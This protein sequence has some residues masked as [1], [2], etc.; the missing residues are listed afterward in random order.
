M[1]ATTVSGTAIG[2]DLT[3]NISFI[4]ES[5][6]LPPIGTSN[7]SYADVW[8][9]NGYAYVGS[10]RSGRGTA[11]FSISNSGIPRYLAQY[12]GI[13]GDGSEYEDVEV[14]DGIGYFGADVSPTSSGTGVDIVDLSIPFDPI[15]L[16]RVN[17]SDCLSGSPTVCA[18][19]KVHTLSI[20]RFNPYTPSE[21]RFLYTA[22]NAT[23][24]V[25]ITDVSN[26][27]SP[28]LIASL[29]LSLSHPPAPYPQ[30]PGTVASHEVVVRNNR[31]YVASKSTSTSTDGWFHIYDVTNPASPVFIKGFLSGA[32]THTAMPS[33]DGKTLIIAEERPGGNV[34]IYD[35]S[36]VTSP[37][38]PDS[39][40]LKATLNTSNV[41]H[42]GTCITGY[43]PHH[44]HLHGNLAFITWYDAGLQV[45]N[46]SNPAAPVLV[47]AYDTWA[48]TSNDY[49]GNWGVDLSMGLKRVLLSDRKRGLIV[50]DA[51]GVLIPGDYNQDMV[52]NAAD[53][54]MW[55]ASFGTTR[56][57]AHARRMQM[58]ITM[59]W[60][61][62]LITFCGGIIWGKCNPAL[63]AGHGLHLLC[64]NPVAFTYWSPVLPR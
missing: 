47:G 33:D 27:S 4:A 12:D 26:P 13:S 1:C 5:N 42:G 20:Q 9:E 54:D 49:N 11:I 34:K 19:N 38:D 63:G 24:V 3:F 25:K 37:N 40:V 44:V 58:A 28:V 18:H 50:V 61:T 8:S 15:P 60:S 21:Q 7:F 32:R 39:P 62:R 59:V 35:I 36:N 51:S 30:L 53:Y 55:R 41:C 23:D 64:R 22:D 57:G 29:D 14:Y 17:S 56:S 52:V 43:S 10:D 46:I 48:G 31:L 16:G 6:P 2:A 45:F